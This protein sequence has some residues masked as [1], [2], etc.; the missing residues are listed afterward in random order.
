MMRLLLA[1]LFVI[2]IAAPA[3]AEDAPLQIAGAT[4]VGAAQVVVMVNDLPQLVIIDNRKPDDFASGAIEGAVPMTD[5]EMTP[6]ALAR[7]AP[8]RDSPLLFYCNGVKCGRAAKAVAK[9]V[10]W[11]YANV[12]YY[13][14]GLAEWNQL[15]LP[16]VMTAQATH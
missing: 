15:G 2:G 11:G 6:E 10:E 12:Y 14:L 13:A 8:S 7:L 16:L 9:A 1:I 5:T 4:T 3:V